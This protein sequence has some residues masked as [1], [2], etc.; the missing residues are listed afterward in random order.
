MNYRLL[1]IIS[2]VRLEAKYEYRLFLFGD[3]VN[4]FEQNK[5]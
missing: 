5:D 3:F 2:V 1:F 4:I